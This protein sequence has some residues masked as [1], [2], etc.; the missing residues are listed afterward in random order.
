MLASDKTLIAPPHT[1]VVP[2]IAAGAEFKVTT[3]DV[4]HPVDS[5]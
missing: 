5:V 4:K 1:V 2:L 3:T